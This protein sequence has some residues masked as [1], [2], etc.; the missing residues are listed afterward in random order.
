MTSITVCCDAGPA[1]GLGH[2]SRCIAMVQ[3]FE[4]AGAPGG[5][6]FVGPVFEPARALVGAAGY[7]YVEGWPENE[8]DDLAAVVRTRGPGILMV[9]G[10]RFGP[11]FV[12]GLRASFTGPIVL[13]DDLHA[14]PSW[15]VDFVVAPAMMA[16]GWRY[17]GTRSFV[18]PR[19]MALRRAFRSR[20]AAGPPPRDLDACLIALS[21]ACPAATLDDAVRA[22]LARFARVRVAAGADRSEVPA[23]LRDD[24][25]ITW[26][27][28]LPHLADE[29]AGCG[30]C[31]CNGGL[32]KYE[33][34]ALGCPAVVVDLTP[35]ERRDTACLLREGLVVDTAG[36][37]GL[38]AGLDAL[39]GDGAM[40]SALGA[41]AWA[42]GV[43]DGVGEVARAVLGDFS[44]A[45]V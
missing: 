38:S 36:G 19:Y 5:A 20:R 37:E 4:D 27:P 34:L 9:D 43:G 15:P 25:R 12:A 13:M 44:A 18:G 30:V 31:V 16:A 11:V 22:V 2:V 24:P 6:R 29:I 14:W 17:P 33:A 42:L 28:P 10:Y 21:R 45:V 23:T 8:V 35:V 40:R 32:T 41:R 26:L 3:A 7:E 39:A 1:V